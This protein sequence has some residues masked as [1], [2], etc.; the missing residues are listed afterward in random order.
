MSGG[1]QGFRRQLP[2]PPGPWHGSSPVLSSQKLARTDPSPVPVGEEQGR[3]LVLPQHR[4]R[5]ISHLHPQGSGA[6]RD[7]AW[8]E[9]GKL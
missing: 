6:G 2:D 8:A 4:P 1:W 5:P 7:P 3:G 9:Q